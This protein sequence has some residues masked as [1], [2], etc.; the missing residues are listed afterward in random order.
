MTP[1]E[2]GNLFNRISEF[3]KHMNLDFSVNGPGEVEFDLIIREFHLSSPKTCHGGVLAAMM[4]TVLGLST[5]SYSVTQD[6]LCST[7]EFKINIFEE[8][9]LG[10]HLRGSAE[11]DFKGNKLVVT[12]GRIFKKDSGDI[13]AKGLGTFNLYPMEKKDL[14][15]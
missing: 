10:D 14:N 1:Q 7:V 5:L 11:L 15:L 13:V 9:K 3:D 2:L 8:V 12:S 4:D 6:K